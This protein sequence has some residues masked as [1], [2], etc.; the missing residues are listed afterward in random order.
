MAPTTRLRLNPGGR[1]NYSRSGALA[2]SRADDSFV[3]S[4]S[5]S[6]AVAGRTPGISP[7]GV[8]KRKANS[9]TN[10]KPAA[11]EEEDDDDE[12]TKPEAKVKTKTKRQPK[13]KPKECIICA[14]EK[15]PRCYRQ[16]EG[17]DFCEYFRDT[18][19]V[20]VQKQLKSKVLDR[21]LDDAVLEC[22]FHDCDGVLDCEAVR[23]M[24]P[25][26]VFQNWDD[27]ITLHYLRVSGDHI[28]CLSSDCGHYFSIENCGPKGTNK[29]KTKQKIECPYCNFGLCL[30][31]NRPWHKDSGCD[32]QKVIEDTHSVQ[33]IKEMGAKAC[34]KC[35]LNIEKNGG[36]DQ[37][38]QVYDEH[39]LDHKH[40]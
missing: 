5:T 10:P 33:A 18:C 17:L 32:K 7:T 4:D 12:R 20:C 16:L 15:G 24:V 19:L 14:T 21:Q 34:P 36:C 26:G 38:H 25:K 9:K 6:Q 40:R 37:P 35:G 29:R 31:C 3:I 39:I 8:G 27:A 28:A 1:V 30:I 22:P 23:Q 13:A 11:K 2:G